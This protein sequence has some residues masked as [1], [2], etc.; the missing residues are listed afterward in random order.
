[1]PGILPS[2]GDVDGIAKAILCLLSDEARRHEMAQR[3]VEK[4]RIEGNEDMWIGKMEELYYS[5]VKE[6]RG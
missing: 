1:M 6:E 4:M 5:L 3:N 2:P